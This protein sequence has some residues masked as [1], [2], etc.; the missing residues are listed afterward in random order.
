[1]SSKI[2][3]A[4]LAIVKESSNSKM[5][6]GTNGV[7]GHLKGIDEVAGSEHNENF[8]DGDV[9][10]LWRENWVATSQVYT[11][12]TRSTAREN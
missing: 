1:M 10:Y 2:G 3:S 5:T 11:G 4:M 6:W 12:T 8:L 9:A 7:P